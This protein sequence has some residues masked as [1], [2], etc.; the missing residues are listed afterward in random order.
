MLSHH[1]EYI[2]ETIWRSKSTSKIPI[3]PIP[4]FYYPHSMNSKESHRFA[5][6]ASTSKISISICL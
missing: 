6:P 3:H 2:S 4:R 5:Y 1:T